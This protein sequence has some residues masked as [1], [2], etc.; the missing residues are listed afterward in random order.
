MTGKKVK[1]DRQIEQN[2]G[3]KLQSDYLLGTEY[4]PVLGLGVSVGIVYSCRLGNG[5]LEAH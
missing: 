4:L 2:L 3:W 5:Y 1:V